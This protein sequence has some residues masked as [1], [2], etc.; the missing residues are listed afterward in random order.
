M[1]LN[2][3]FILNG[4]DYAPLTF[5]GIGIFMAFS[6][7]GAYRNRGSFANV[8]KVGPLPAGKY[9]IVDRSEGGLRSKVIANSKDL[10]NKTF[11]HAEFG[12]SD[13]F[14]LWRND[15]NIDDRT[16]VEAV[17]RENFRLHPGSISDGCI[18][19]SSNSDFRRLRNALL[20]TTLINVPCMSNLKARGYIEVIGV[21]SHNVCP[22][23]M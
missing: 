10:F 15:W 11:R 17:K 4:A 8:A 12:H 13:W 14:A 6:G 19:L 16:W 2:G 3:T 20:N 7:N 18:T 21:N 23:P 5:P 1:A 9:W 22:R